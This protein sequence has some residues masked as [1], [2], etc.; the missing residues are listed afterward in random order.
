MSEITNLGS[1]P[2][3]FR[4]SGPEFTLAFHS[5]TVSL[6][7]IE[8]SLYALA[9]VLTGT[10][11]PADEL[12]NVR[13]VGRSSSASADEMAHG[14]R[15]EVNDQ[16]LRIRIAERTSGLRDLVFAYAFSRSSLIEQQNQ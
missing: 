12:W 11:E 15:Q 10:V 8:R 5:Q 3:P 16:A 2:I 4:G 9:D 7:A 13:I 6:E 14:F 1:A